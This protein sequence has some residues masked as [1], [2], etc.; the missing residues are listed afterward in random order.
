MFFSRKN[1]LESDRYAVVIGSSSLAVFLVHLLQEKGVDVTLV[2]DAEKNNILNNYV[3]KS[4]FQNQDVEIRSS[5]FIEKRPEFCFL[6]SSFNEYQK[7]LIYLS[8]EILKG[9][10]IINFAS[11]Y[12]R[13]LIEQLDNIEEIRAYFNGF[14]VKAKKE[15]Y[16]LNRV[17]DITICCEAEVVKEL[18]NLLTSKKTNVK[19]AKNTK[20]LF[21]QELVPYLLGNLYV[22]MY[23]SD[24]SQILTDNNKRQK[25]DL[26]IAEVVKLLKKAKQQ[27][28]EQ[29][30]LPDIY[31]FPDGFSSEFDS[32]QGVEALSRLIDGIDY[33]ETPELFEIIS[34]VYKKY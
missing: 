29:K 15:V 17:S 24:I 20:K 7:D 26:M 2:A 28:D 11:F 22:L 1:D 16:H 32:L 13:K 21:W 27:I 31:A 10:P 33:F 4:A 18:K 9:V 19:L 14:L 30:I 12:N 6:A 5:K 3:I 25:L 23:Q 8:D 34:K